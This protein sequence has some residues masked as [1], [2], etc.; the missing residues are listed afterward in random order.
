MLLLSTSPG[1]RGG[2]TVLEHAQKRIAFINDNRVFSFSLPSYQSSFSE[3]AGIVDATL[4][5]VFAT[6]FELFVGVLSAPAQVAS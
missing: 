1:K 2:K 4:A 3:D 6:Q 5:N